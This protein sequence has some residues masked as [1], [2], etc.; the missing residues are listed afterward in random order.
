MKQCESVT[1]IWKFAR[2][3]LTLI[4]CLC[5]IDTAGIVCGRV[6]VTYGVRLSVRLS[7]I[8]RNRDKLLQFVWAIRS[9]Q[10]RAAGLLLLARRAGD[11][12]RQRR[13]STALSSKCEQCHV[14]SWR[15]KPNTDLLHSQSVWIFVRWTQNWTEQQINARIPQTTSQRK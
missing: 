6:Y 9:L 8:S 2:W 1:K 3:S 13:R 5:F 14:V 10:Q 12:D 15:R 7:E 11:I 4:N